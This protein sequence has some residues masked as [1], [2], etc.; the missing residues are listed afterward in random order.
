MVRG[1]NTCPLCGFPQEFS[2][3]CLWKENGTIV[4]AG[5]PRHR[6]LFLEVPSL[7]K[8]LDDIQRLLGMPIDRIVSEGKRKTTLEYLRGL[9]PGWK[10]R[11][12][13]ALTKQVAYRKIAETGALMGY[14]HYELLE[15][16]RK[17]RVRVYGENVYLPAFFAGDLAAVFNVM[18][19]LPARLEIEESGKGMVITVVPGEEDN[20]LESRVKVRFR[21]VKPGQLELSRCSC[22]LPQEISA[23][24]CDP[25]NGII[26]DGLT[27]RRAAVV[28]LEGLESVLRE[29]QSEL[30][31]DIRI[32]ASNSFRD[33]LLESGA[34]GEEDDTSRL[35][36]W[37]ALR[38]MGNLVSVEETAGGRSFRVE[39]PG[40]S[41][42]LEGAILAFHQ[43]TVGSR[44]KAFTTEEEGDLIVRIEG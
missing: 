34:F 16:S 9:F 30:G 17:K 19:G 3:Q 40:V 28:G 23:G 4:Q 5:N 6:L 36:L 2:R 15:T 21:P 37:L 12:A 10:L 43:A 18:E 25:K 11:L 42:F 27:G 31:E 39:N 41:P 24:S 13:R 38:G 32:Q 22:G 26:I 44:G 14:G 33:Y 20:L 8:V 7:A 29:L 1:R 35:R